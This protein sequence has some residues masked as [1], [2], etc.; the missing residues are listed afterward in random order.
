MSKQPIFAVR[1]VKSDA[2]GQPFVSKH[3]GLAVRGLTD[4]VND[5]Q[6]QSDIAR[7][8]EDFSLYEI[9]QYDDQTGTIESYDVPK[10]VASASSLQV[11]VN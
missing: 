9:G 8:P 11:T 5:P 10:L 7:H 3:V 4:A 1:D 6:K 2:F